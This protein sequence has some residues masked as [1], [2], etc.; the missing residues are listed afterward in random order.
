MNFLEFIRI[1]QECSILM[2]IG[3]A[4]EYQKNLS[5]KEL[6]LYIYRASK[7]NKSIQDVYNH[8]KIA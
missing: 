5:V 1:R 7:K 2:T 3:E 4:I 6:V 8:L